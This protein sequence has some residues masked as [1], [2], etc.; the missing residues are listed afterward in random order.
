[1]IGSFKT[2]PTVTKTTNIHFQNRFIKIAK[3][4]FVIIN[5]EMT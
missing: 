2:D 1:V 5:R 3:N 4:V